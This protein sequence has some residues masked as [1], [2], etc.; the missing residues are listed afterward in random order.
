MH[1]V[2]KESHSLL[3]IKIFLLA[4]LIAAFASTSYKLFLLIKESS[5]KHDS[6][7]LLIEGKNSYLVHLEKREKKMSIID[8]MRLGR[9]FNNKNRIE[10]SLTVNI[11]IDGKISY[12]AQNKEELLPPAKL[13]P[14][15]FLSSERYKF[16]NIN[17]FDLLKFIFF[18]SLVRG[19]DRVYLD[20]NSGGDTGISSQELFDSFG[21][22]EIIN[23][24]VSIEII[25][26]TD[27]DG[28]GAKISQILKNSGY[29]VIAISTGKGKKTAVITKKRGSA[30]VKKLSNFFNTRAVEGE[31]SGIA[32]VS[33]IIGQDFAKNFD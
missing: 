29:N 20:I 14:G 28:L 16:E 23:E 32:D 31:R 27:I 24:K 19:A 11:P 15:V 3:Y 22:R 6:F 13:V 21:D 30:T 7:N 18:S 17:Q 33:L 12:D 9:I 4:V 8:F 5:F 26:A 25:N 2:K 10:A 1:L